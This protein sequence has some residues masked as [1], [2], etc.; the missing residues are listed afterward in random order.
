MSSG[1]AEKTKTCTLCGEV[2]PRSEFKLSIYPPAPGSK[3]G[4]KKYWSARCDLCRELGLDVRTTPD[5]PV[6]STERHADERSPTK[7]CSWCQ[8]TKPVTD[9]AWR[10]QATRSRRPRCRDCEQLDRQRER[11]RVGDAEIRR[12]NRDAQR[13]HRAEWSPEDRRE[14]AIQRRAHHRAMAELREIHRAEFDALYEQA[15]ELES[16]ELTEEFE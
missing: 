9:F 1:S 14:S 7:V 10:N 4:P 16:E 3:R 13:R 12:R 2:K 8:K 11:A 15:K 6:P 5:D